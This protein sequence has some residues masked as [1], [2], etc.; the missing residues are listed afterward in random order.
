MKGEAPMSVVENGFYVY[1]LGPV[2]YFDGAMTVDQAI[3]SSNEDVGQ[4]ILRS[5]LQAARAVIDESS[6]EGTITDGPYVIALP[7]VDG[8]FSLLW[9]FIWKQNNNGTTFIASPLPLWW[10]DE[11]SY[12]QTGKKGHGA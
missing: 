11:P 6:W 3:K 5:F 9:G 12:S 8:D 1:E 7:P 2:D 10:L 4:E